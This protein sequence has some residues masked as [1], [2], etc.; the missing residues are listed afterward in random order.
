MR[1][2]VPQLH[3]RAQLDDPIGGARED[4]AAE[5]LAERLAGHGDALALL[6]RPVGCTL[7]EVLHEALVL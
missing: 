2:S 3:C 5:G 4:A 1:A 6:L 7:L